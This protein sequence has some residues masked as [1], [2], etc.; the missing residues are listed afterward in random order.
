MAVSW[1]DKRLSWNEN[2]WNLKKLS[3]NSIA[4][5]WVPLITAQT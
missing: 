3:I 2:D 1:I 4:H 5:V